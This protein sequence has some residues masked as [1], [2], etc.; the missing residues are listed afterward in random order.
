MSRIAIRIDRLLLPPGV[1]AKAETI[2]TALAAELAAL[3]HDPVAL[4]RLAA[5]HGAGVTGRVNV[6]GTT[7]P[8]IASGVARALRGGARP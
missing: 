4:N 5:G 7:A 3:A 2:E 6:R 8:Q 1:P